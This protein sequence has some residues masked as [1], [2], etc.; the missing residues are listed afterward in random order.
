[1]K[2]FQILNKLGMLF[3]SSSNPFLL[4]GEGAFSQVFKA[5]RLSDNTEYALKKVSIKLLKGVQ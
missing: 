3:L 2:N 4:I 5:K 1:M